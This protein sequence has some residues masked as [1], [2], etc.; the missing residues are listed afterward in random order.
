MRDLEEEMILELDGGSTRLSSVQNSL[1][2]IGCEPIVR[3]S[4]ERRF[5][6]KIN[7]LAPELFF[8]F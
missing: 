1:W 4:T 2:P 5:A 8:K 3:Q 6:M 7:L